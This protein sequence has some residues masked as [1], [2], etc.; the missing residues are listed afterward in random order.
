MHKN[1]TEDDEIAEAMEAIDKIEVDE[2]HSRLL[3][4]SIASAKD[5]ARAM[6][7]AQ[8]IQEAIEY[9]AQNETRKKP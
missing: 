8:K 5:N 2:L 4:M 9:L 6:E 1:F 7:L 3:S